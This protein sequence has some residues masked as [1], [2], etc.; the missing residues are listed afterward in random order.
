MNERMIVPLQDG[1]ILAQTVWGGFVVVP[2]YNVDVTVGIVRDGLHEPWTTRLIQELVQEGNIYVN[3][4]ANFGYYTVLG[5]CRVGPQGKVISIEANPH[6]FSILMRTIVWSGVIDRVEAYNIAAY[7][8][9]DVELEFSFDYQFIG[10]GH[11]KHRV[12]EGIDQTKTPFWSVESVPQLVNGDGK[13]IYGQGLLNFLKVK[14]RKLDTILAN[15]ERVD[16][17]HMDVE[18]AEPY[19]I[20]G[21]LDILRRSGNTKIVFEWSEYAYV[22]GSDEYKKLAEGMYDL[23]ME[24]GYHVRYLLPL[25]HSDGAISVSHP[26]SKEEFFKGTH[27]DYIAIPK[28]EDP[29]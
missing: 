24:M 17:L 19:V 15:L 14:T 3:V 29:W 18:G 1:L 23:F 7:K 6:V 13:W 11:F 8:E 2:G 10:G 20:S 27:G 26:L 22:N 5:G 9:D 16:V 25:I 28:G 12:E 21:A 4:G